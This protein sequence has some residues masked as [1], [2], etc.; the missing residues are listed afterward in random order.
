MV[1]AGELDLT[2]RPVLA[3]HCRRSCGPGRGGSSWIWPVP[4][5]WIAAPRA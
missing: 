4:A 5:S 1:I 3:E 2:T